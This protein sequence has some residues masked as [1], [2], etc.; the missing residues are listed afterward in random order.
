MYANS[1]KQ[2]RLSRVLS[3]YRGKLF[4]CPIDDSLLCGPQGRLL[5]LRSLLVAFSTLRPSA[6]VGYEAPLRHFPGLIDEIPYFL[7]ATASI[8]GPNH[9]RKVQVASARHALSLGADGLAGH[10]NL[11]SVY[12][13][14]MIEMIGKLSDECRE[15]QLPF[16][17][18]AYLRREGA[19]GDD[20]YYSM[21]ET[22]PDQYARMVAHAVRIAV[23]LGADI[24]K[25]NYVGPPEYLEVILD[26]ACNVPLI[27]AGGPLETDDGAITMRISNALK[28][29]VSG[30]AFGR[31]LYLREN[32]EQLYRSIED[33]L[34]SPQHVEGAQ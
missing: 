28:K 21:A 11:S 32:M 34:I 7:N 22:Q 1:G 10:F 30:I 16:L 33:L 26:A 4:F 19:D 15:Y 31:N 17:V 18:M 20:N 27:L 5:N 9:V 6:I 24:V 25:T 13:R 23:E 8:F 14:E 2:R 3:R 29:G 12:D